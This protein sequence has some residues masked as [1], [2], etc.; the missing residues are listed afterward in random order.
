MHF[1][2]RNH[3]FKTSFNMASGTTCLSD[4]SLN[5]FRPERTRELLII[6]KSN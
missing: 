3:N 6:M 1:H 4:D 5:T 2:A